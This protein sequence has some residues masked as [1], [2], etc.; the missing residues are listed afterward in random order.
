MNVIFQA[1]I[2][3]LV[4]GD[5]V[6]L[7]KVISEDGHTY[8]QHEHV[9][10]SFIRNIIHKPIQQGQFIPVRLGSMQRYNTCGTTISSNGTLLICDN[11]F[12]VY[13]IKG[14]LNTND[15][16]QLMQILSNIQ[17]LRV[18]INYATGNI[19]ASILKKITT[20]PSI[21]TVEI[22]L[23]LLYSHMEYKIPQDT[24][25]IES[26]LDMGDE[27]DIIIFKDTRIPRETTLVQTKKPD[28]IKNIEPIM[29]TPFRGLYILLMMTLNIL[30][31]IKTMAEFYKTT[32]PG[33][34]D[35]IFNI[36]MECKIKNN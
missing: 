15:R 3:F 14:T 29:T 12:N 11:T 1:E 18:D 23:Y 27:F 19:N 36:W 24:T 6:D 8:G 31:N 4:E 2:L 21:I 22:L 26:V 10:I 13:N 34:Y 35:K 5:I 9:T 28:E 7:V 17:N 32:N 33:E 20:D 16:A 25:S 30:K